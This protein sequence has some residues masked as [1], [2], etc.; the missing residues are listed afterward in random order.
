MT[1]E[2]ESKEKLNLSKVH[3]KN[4]HIKR[5]INTEKHGFLTIQIP[6]NWKSSLRSDPFR[7]SH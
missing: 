3:H 6:P 5:S 1:K 2:D 4:L 7:P